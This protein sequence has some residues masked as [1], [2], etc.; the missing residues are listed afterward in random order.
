ML[1]SYAMVD[2]NIKKGKIIIYRL[3]DIAS[4]INLSLLE[5]SAGEATKRLRLSREPYVKAIEFANPP[6]SIE[7]KSF[8]KN[9]FGQDVNINVVAKT[10]DFG[11]LS[12][13]FDIPIPHDTTFTELEVVV[14]EL[15][16]DESINEK[17]KEYAQYLLNTF[18][19]AFVNHAIKEGFI[20]DYT[21]FFIERLDR[22]IESSEFMKHYD[23]SRLLLYES[24]QISQHMKEETLKY[25][26][27][28][29]TNDIVILHLDNAFIIDP[30]GSSDILDI[31][32]FANAQILELRYYDHVIDKELDRIYSELPERGGVSIFKLRN[33]E[34][35]VRKITETVTE[36]TKV[37][38][39]VDNALKVTEDIY[40][41]KIYRTAM[42]IFRS[43]DWEE[44][45]KEKLQIVT[46]TY[47]ML[48]NEITTKR[49]HIL[50]FTIVILI[51][52][53]IILVII[54][55]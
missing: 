26:F 16:I 30:S 9:L 39:R 17:A 51:L 11:V 52:I 34:R 1:L 53:D 31:L 13:A 8:T 44:S 37:T 12:L 19:N 45:I 4:E 25:S 5:T 48:Y 27:S 38:E 41:A 32:E 47:R 20:E 7:L 55:R 28:Y 14:K 10:Y 3:F 22:E 50:E 23:P 33:Y 54:W 29:Y 18:G 46:N 43:R 6:L 21:I 49:G 2:V 40:Y 24:G 36:L 42:T 15:D 35:L